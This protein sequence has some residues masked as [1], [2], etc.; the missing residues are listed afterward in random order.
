MTEGDLNNSVKPW[1][2]DSRMDEEIQREPT[3]A[4][5]ADTDLQTE[6]EVIRVRRDDYSFDDSGSD[7][8]REA[9]S[10]DSD[11]EESE[12]AM[13]RRERFRLIRQIV[14]GTILNADSVRENFRYA[15]GLAVMLFAS[16]FMLFTSLNL[17][18]RYMKLEREVHLLRE[19]AIRMSEQKYEN[20]SHSAIVR[21][22]RERGIDLQDPQEPHE[23]LD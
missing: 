9:E 3:A 14:L 23:L 19:R 10:E 17:Y 4:E 7:G 5:R 12:K 2:D 16:I 21:R 11:S 1:R 6:V 20:S 13:T 8:A 18:L 22:L 15:I